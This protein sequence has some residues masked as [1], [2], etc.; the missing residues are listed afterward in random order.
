MPIAF[1]R[2]TTSKSRLKVDWLH[3]VPPENQSLGTSAAGPLPLADAL[4]VLWEDDDRPLLVL[5]ECMLC[6]GSDAALFDSSMQNDRAV[7]LT[8]WFRVVRLPPNVSE[9]GHAFYNVFA[10]YPTNGPAAHFFLLAHPKA[11]PV[12]FTGMQ[13]PSS[14]W[15]GMTSVLEQRYGKD[16]QKAVKQWLALLDQ[17][18]RI[19]IALA[20]KQAEM[21]ETRADEGPQ[22]SKA[23]RLQ[24]RIDDLQQ[25]REE[26]IADEA[27]VRDLKMLATGKPSELH[28]AR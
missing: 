16:P 20:S 13:T 2:G 8:K 19:D 28:A 22:S 17:F 15:R 25:E 10:A 23:K 4:R 18:D 26:L 5:R 1:T 27:K 11:E 6:S 7:L 9:P 12:Q 3:P 24:K 14:L 21:D